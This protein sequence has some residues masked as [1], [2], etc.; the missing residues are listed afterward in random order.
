M[1]FTKEIGG[2]KMIVKVGE[3]ANQAN[4]SC[5][6]QYGETTVLAT[7][8]LGSSQ[9]EGVDY[10][11]LS[12]EY[13]ERFY[14]AGKIKGSRFIKRETRPADE[15]VLTGRL[16]DRSI[17]PLFDQA[18]RRAVQVVLTVLSVDQ[19]NDPDVVAFCAGSIA[20]AISDIEWEG[21][22]AGVRVSRTLDDAEGKGQWI[23]NPSYDER[24]QSDLDLF[25]SG[26]NGRVLMIEAGAKDVNDEVMAEAIQYGVK[27]CDEI[28]NFIKEIQE[29]VGKEKIPLVIKTPSPDETPTREELKKMTEDIVNKEA[30]KYLFSELLKSRKDRI[31]AA[32]KI[33]EKLEE[34]LLEKNIGKEKRAKAIEYANELIYHQVSL[35]I[36]DKDKRVD[37]RKLNEIRP[38]SC[39]AGVLP[40]VHGS[41]L[42]SRGET[43]VLSVVTLGAPGSEQY[44]DTMEENIRKPFMHHYNFPPF[45]TGEVKPM[46]STSRREIGHGA[47]VEK[48]MLPVMPDREGF[49]Y[50]VRIVSEVL[51]SNGSSSMASLCASVLAT[52]DAGIPIKKP[53]AG[54]A[55]GLASEEDSNGFKRYKVLTDMQDLEDGPG[56][57]DF[58][59]IGSKDGIMAIQ[60]DTKTKGL[61]PEIIKETFRASKLARSQ[62]LDKMTSVLSKAR[63]E[64][65]QYAPRVV[66]FRINPGKIRDVIGPGGKTIN[67]II[68][69]TGAM[70]EIEQTGVVSISSP[71]KESLSKAVKWVKDITR[72]LEVG[73]V[74]EGKVVKIMDFGA[75]IE[76]VPGQDGLLHISK[77][78]DHRINH[79]SDIMKEGDKIQVKII[80]INPQGKISLAR[81]MT[82]V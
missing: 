27:A 32:E 7:A 34:I 59:I 26:L 46:R 38:I 40:R 80:D 61:T 3:V 16:I 82:K 58:K 2:K 22:I 5:V 19:E 12:V 60:L 43:Q 35:G 73:E 71:D 67:E 39:S 30:P 56:G 49:P 15:A 8:V 66:V 81:V 42:F 52:M 78:S 70:I 31:G 47:L 18:C 23:L 62:I 65:S 50:T 45:C 14:A 79:P 57:M 69:K 10:F 75:F 4:G 53:V 54:I 21:P 17:R 37:G 55:I 1:E 24:E 25:V 6:V 9:R 33:R 72:E 41:A 68:N 11:P 74:F 48:G 20:L 36:L 51:S 29:K 44:L 28:N 64:L 63:E 76:L 13:E 77:M